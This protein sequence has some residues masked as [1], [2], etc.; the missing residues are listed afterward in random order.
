MCLICCSSGVAESL[1]PLTQ[2]LQQ[3][4][5]DRNDEKSDDDDDDD[6]IIVLLLLLLF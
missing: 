5:H 6:G 1:V 2:A 3:R 4:L